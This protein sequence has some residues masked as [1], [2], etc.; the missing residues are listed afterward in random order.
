MPSD[1]PILLSLTEDLWPG[2]GSG[3]ESS[4]RVIVSDAEVPPQ[5]YE[6]T[7]ETRVL[8]TLSTDLD[9]S[10]ESTLKDE[11]YTARHTIAWIVSLA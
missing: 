4:A 7:N 1:V 6:P 10:P 11:W 8:C 5:E 3:S 9:K 2:E